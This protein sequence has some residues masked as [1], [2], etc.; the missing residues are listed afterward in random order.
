MKTKLIF[1]TETN[2]SICWT[3]IPFVPRINEMINISDIL[4]QE[5]I[6]EIQKSANC[7]TGIRGKVKSVEYRHDDD[8]FYVEL[9]IWCED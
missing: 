2:D 1:S 4:R 7:W 6:E 9:N 8:E 3:D 5:E